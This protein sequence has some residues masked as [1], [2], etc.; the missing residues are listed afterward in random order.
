MNILLFYRGFKMHTDELKMLLQE[1]SNYIISDSKI[2]PYICLYGEENNPQNSKKLINYAI[3]SE[4]SFDELTKILNGFKE[5]INKYIHSGNAVNDLKHDSDDK[6]TYHKMDEKDF[7]I[8]HA[9]MNANDS[10][11]KFADFLKPGKLKNTFLIIEL[12]LDEVGR[13]KLLLCRS[14][15]QNYYSAK[16]HKFSLT[17]SYNK[18]PKITFI[19]KKKDLLISDNFDIV[20][21]IDDENH[22]SSFIVIQNIKKF[23]DL[24]RYHERY[25]DAYNKLSET[26]DF[27]KWNNITPSLSL[28]RKCYEIANFNDFEECVEQLK[29][30]LLSKE[31]NDI[32]RAFSSKGL[33]YFTGEKG[34]LIIVPVSKTDIKSLLMIIKDGVAKTAL[35]HRSVLG[36][37]YE[38][39]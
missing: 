39:L 37:N 38:V 12:D 35:L 13:K 24:Y 25:D 11:I 33:E 10:N 20:A 30:D 36:S 22:D 26:L 31:N 5:R 23:E 17:I 8:T 27:V 18:N 34:E 2:N 6:L 15:S 19:D 7:E 4:D 9:I 29:T 16:N 28:K 32:K 21:F 1:L 14:I 3:S